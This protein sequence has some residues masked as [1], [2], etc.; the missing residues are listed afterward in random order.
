MRLASVAD[1]KKIVAELHAELPRNDLVVWTAGHVSARVPGDD[2][3]VIKPSGISYDV[4]RAD[5]MV[6]TDLDGNLVEGGHK[7]F[8]H[9]AAQRYVYEHLADVRGVVDAH[10]TCVSA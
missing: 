5:N 8:C 4:I 1:I 6:V 9:P 10:S 2:L 7:P 3:L